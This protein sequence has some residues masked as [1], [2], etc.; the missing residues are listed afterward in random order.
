VER[1][2]ALKARVL[3][4]PYF[5]NPADAALFVQLAAG[6]AEVV[7][8]V[9]TAAA[10]ERLPEIV[11][12]PELREIMIGL[13]DLQLSLGLANPFEVVVSDQM[14][15]AAQCVLD[16][17]LRFGFGGLARV[18]DARLPIEPDLVVAQYP[19]LGANTAW[20]AR[21]FFREIGPSEVAPALR[22]LRERLRYWSAQPSWELSEQRDRLA[23]AI[24]RAIRRATAS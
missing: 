13:N 24:Q 5:T 16:A 21:S 1:A 14:Q 9:E 2:L 19:R 12:I 6:R 3:M 10:F 15:R 18:D 17:G 7:P 8:L 22:A 20:L 11:R 23:S 4:L